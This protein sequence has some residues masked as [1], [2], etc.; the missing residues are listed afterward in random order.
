MKR[1]AFTQVTF[2]LPNVQVGAAPATFT[3]HYEAPKDEYDCIAVFDGTGFTFERTGG[4]VKNLRW[5]FRFLAM[6]LAL[7]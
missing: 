4:H 2:Q 5:C 1:S 7:P 3:G 6:Q